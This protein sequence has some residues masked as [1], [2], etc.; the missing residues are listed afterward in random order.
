MAR[1]P[2]LNSTVTLTSHWTDCLPWKINWGS[3]NQA[4]R[5]LRLAQLRPSATANH[6]LEI[7]N[8]KAF[9]SRGHHEQ[10]G[11]LIGRDQTLLIDSPEEAHALGDPNFS[12]N[13]LEACAV[14]AFANIDDIVARRTRSG[15]AAIGS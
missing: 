14:I 6:C 5:E 13:L 15:I 3:N 1:A 12:N 10:I 7:A 2:G 9:L 4:N 11:H 8:A